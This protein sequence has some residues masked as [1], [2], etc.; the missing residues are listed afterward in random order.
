M[1][2]HDLD[3]ADYVR[4]AVSD[5]DT[6]TIFAQSEKARRAIYHRLKADVLASKVVTFDAA[7]SRVLAEVSMLPPDQLLRA[8]RSARLPW[9]QALIVI[10]FHTYLQGTRPLGAPVDKENTPEQMPLLISTD[11]TGSRGTATFLARIRLTPSDRDAGLVC[12]PVGARYD[13]SGVTLPVPDPLCRAVVRRAMTDR[14]QARFNNGKGEM[15]AHLEER[16][17]LLGTD[18]TQPSKE[19]AI[20]VVSEVLFGRPSEDAWSLGTG[21]IPAKLREFEDVRGRAVAWRAALRQDVDTLAEIGRMLTPVFCP[22]SRASEFNFADDATEGERQV[23]EIA[24]KAAMESSG[25]ARLVL[26]I[27]AVLGESGAVSVEV[28]RPSGARMVGTRRVPFMATSRVVIDLAHLGIVSPFRAPGS[29]SDGS[30]GLVAEHAV[31]G[32][33]VHYHVDRTRR[34]DHDWKPAA[35]RPTG[36]AARAD[37]V[38]AATIDGKRQECACGALRVWRSEHVRGSAA[39]GTKLG[40]RVDVIA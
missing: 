14:L 15:A 11:D 32:H 22:Y 21:F 31:R 7:A 2:P 36:R 19:A 1:K 9:P 34:C 27:L 33:W 38:S 30:R 17:K 24:M 12:E 37:V 18:E 35:K 28:G 6:V 20:E 10:D 13:F 40:K 16:L 4:W 29:G 8:A 39:R 3:A 25:T 5:Y 26:A 23:A